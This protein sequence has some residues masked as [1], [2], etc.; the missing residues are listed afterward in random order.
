MSL[1]YLGTP[2]K[3]CGHIIKNRIV[4]PPM[5]N[6]ALR[7]GDGFVKP[8][9]LQYYGAYASGG[10][11]LVIVEACT[12]I[13]VPDVLSVYDD[14][15]IDGMSKLAEVI[16]SAGAVPMIQLLHDGLYIL[17]ENEIAQI[18]H[19]DFLRYK[20]MF[21]DAALRCKKAGFAGVEL[22]AAHGFYLNQIL[23]RNSRT[24]EYG[25]SFANRVRIIRELIQE[26][27]ELCGKNFIVAVR[28]GNPNYE[29]LLQIAAAIEEAGGDLLDVSTG[30]KGYEGVPSDF[31][32]DAKIYAAS[33]VKRQ[34]RIPVIGVGNIFTGEQAEQILEK[35]YADMIA[36]GR[37]HLCDPAWAN[38][39]FAGQQPKLCRNC[40]RCM[41]Y[42]DSR[43]CPAC[44]ER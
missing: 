20:Q 7:A 30:C 6:F 35:R 44:K 15:C 5:A 17:Q 40:R 3:V 21:I 14:S 12:V 43:K 8:G 31:G 27:K 29:E 33:L 25:G 9:H 2:L 10:A 13:S 19:I 26:I 42:V 11:G 18:S 37:G 32:F 1:E 38:K 41:W 36:V 39:E 28:F 23:E 22:H 4:V 24:D 16:S 34:A